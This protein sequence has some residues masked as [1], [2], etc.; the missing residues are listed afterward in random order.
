MKLK[1]TRKTWYFL[2]LASAAA[3]MLN[4]FAVLSGTSFGLIE[5]IAF[6]AA[7][8]AALFLAAEKGSASWEKRNF[9][10]VFVLLM[11]SYMVNGWAGYLCSALAWPLLLSTEYKRGMAIQRQLQ[12]VGAAEAFHLLFVL[13]TVYGGMAGLSFWANLL[14]VLL[15][16]ARAGA[17]ES[18]DFLDTHYVRFPLELGG[19]CPFAPYFCLAEVLETDAGCWGVFCRKGEGDYQPLFPRSAEKDRLRGPDGLC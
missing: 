13:L 7:G 12:L 5:Q 1:F 16:C 17:L 2:L 15:A 19:A 8:I 18:A 11:V 6:A 14:W 9:T 4:G 3:S 10:G